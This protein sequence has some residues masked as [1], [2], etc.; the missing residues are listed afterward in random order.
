[1][2]TNENKQK[3]IGELVVLYSRHF[4]VPFPKW[5]MPSLGEDQTI[6]LIEKCIKNNKKI[7]Y[8]YPEDEDTIV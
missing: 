2:I 4:G 1:M 3:R 7:E 5:G 6:A 8:Y